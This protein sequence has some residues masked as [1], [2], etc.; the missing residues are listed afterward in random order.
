MVTDLVQ[1]EKWA[2]DERHEILKDMYVLALAG[3]NLRSATCR[4]IRVEL[5]TTNVV[6]QP[7]VNMSKMENVQ[8][9]G[10]RH[11]VCASQ[12]R[13]NQRLDLHVVPRNKQQLPKWFVLVVA[14]VCLSS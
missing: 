2:Q 6:Q 10:L 1:S 9:I 13:Q 14:R 3:V 8:Q 5:E 11:V 7:I 12:D 4:D